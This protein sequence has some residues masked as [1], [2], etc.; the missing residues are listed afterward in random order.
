MAASLK[1]VVDQEVGPQICD[2]GAEVICQ[3]GAQGGANSGE[4]STVIAEVGGDE[5]VMAYFVGEYLE[6]EVLES[7]VG[8][9]TKAD[10]DAMI[11]ESNHGKRRG[12]SFSLL[13][14]FG[15]AVN[16]GLEFRKGAPCLE[17]LR[18]GVGPLLEEGFLSFIHGL[19]SR[20]R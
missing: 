8:D 14:P 9:L 5:D 3:G 13:F 15:K 18:P 20:G 12:K 10:D 2:D 11:A 19:I 17:G 7:Q 6:C 16:R 4:Y 1:A